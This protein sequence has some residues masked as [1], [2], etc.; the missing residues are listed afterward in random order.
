MNKE[1]LNARYWV[2]DEK[3]VFPF[4]KHKGKTVKCVFEEDPSY[5]AYCMRALPK[6]SLTVSG[7]NYLYNVNKGYFD[8]DELSWFYP[9]WVNK[10]AEINRI[11]TENA[12]VDQGDE[13]PASAFVNTVAFLIADQP[14][15]LARLRKAKKEVLNSKGDRVTVEQEYAPANCFDKPVSSDENMITF[16]VRIVDTKDII[17]FKKYDAMAST[18]GVHTFQILHYLPGG[19]SVYLA[20]A[21]DRR[22]FRA[23]NIN[24]GAGWIMLLPIDA[25]CVM[26]IVNAQ[27][28]TQVQVGIRPMEDAEI[29]EAIADA[30]KKWGASA[31]RAQRAY[32]A[33]DMVPV[34]RQ[35]SLLEEIL[36]KYVL[37]RRAFPSQNLLSTTPLHQYRSAL[38]FS[39]HTDAVD[40]LTKEWY[41]ANNDL[42][43]Y[44][45]RKDAVMQG[46]RAYW[47]SQDD[48][49]D[50]SDP[51]RD[52]WEELTDGQQGSWDDWHEPFPPY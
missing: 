49:L 45:R 4:G 31:K 40:T 28:V 24:M 8:S 25:Q 2:F 12:H 30:A 17:S 37:F 52:N 11:L 20:L 43:T 33:G 15:V 50:E 13:L 47:R 48:N 5:L 1:L 39:L 16:F 7:R 9:T 46:R 51:E 44:E 27:V 35:V 41:Q 32:Y 19:E 34:Y 18:P 22:N 6:F 10:S 21:M 38:S 26:H 36:E 42:A 14:I 23:Q 3:S 29:D